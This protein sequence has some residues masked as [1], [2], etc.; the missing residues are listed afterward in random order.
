MIIVATA[1][2]GLGVDRPDIRTV[3]VAS[4]PADLAGLYQELGRAGRDKSAGV[5]VMIGSPRAFRTL[6][7]MEGLGKTLDPLRVAR[8]AGPI[9]DGDGPLDV[10][11]VALDL[12]GQ[13]IANGLVNESEAGSAE[14]LGEYKT[15]VVRVLA[16][17]AEDG[18]VEDRGDFPDVVKV[19]LR[20]DAPGA[21]PEL[22]TLLDAIVRNIATPDAVDIIGLSAALAPIFPEEAGDP[23]DLWVRLLELHSLGY[24]DVS[25]MPTKRQMTSLIRAGSRLP[26]G[27]ASRF[28]SRLRA[29]ERQRLVEFFGR[30]ESPTCVNDDFRLY[31]EEPT[32]PEGT[33]S[34]DASRCS[35]CWRAGHGGADAV[36]PRLLEVL[37]DARPRPAR[38][39]EGEMRGLQ[40]RI[41]RNV[42]R[43]LRA[44]WG[45]L[46]PFLIEK[47]LRGEDH[48]YS[49]KTGKMEPLWPELVNSAVF[50]AMPSLKRADLD[51]TIVALE[52]ADKVR[53]VAGDMP[54]FRYV[55][56]IRT[57]EARAATAAARLGQQSLG[58]EVGT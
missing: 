15:S 45:S 50:G 31:F 30:R 11:A 52:A 13:D 47:T 14:T 18:I 7:F 5:G 27:F 40:S 53:R 57:E 29:E 17:L 20:D 56:H 35:G 51:A 8:I 32:L 24:L 28:I 38:R 33:C 6:A 58:L 36:R 42:E 2:F 10:E 23:G 46:T 16:A 43:L 55:E 4:P 12:L 37:T 1:A 21:E 22:A 34:T 25:Q 54:R 44:R 9:L 48:F 41:G 39:T 19:V 3:V 49:R 26:S